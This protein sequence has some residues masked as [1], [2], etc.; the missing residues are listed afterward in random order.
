MAASRRQVQRP[1]RREAEEAPLGV[2]QVEQ[3]MEVVL[4][5]AASMLAR[6]GLSFASLRRMEEQEEDSAEDVLEELDE[7][8]A[9]AR[10]EELVTPTRSLE[11]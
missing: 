10:D 4:V 5:G 3:R 7:P 8:E 6:E 9:E 2:E 11:R 1:A